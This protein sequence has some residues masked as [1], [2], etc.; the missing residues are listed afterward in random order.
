MKWWNV[1]ADVV[2][3]LTKMITST[4]THAKQTQQASAMVLKRM[5]DSEDGATQNQNEA[6]E[7]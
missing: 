3:A 7:E 6:I 5:E 1:M 2:R 4:H